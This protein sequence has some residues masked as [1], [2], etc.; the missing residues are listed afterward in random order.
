[1]SVS[2]QQADIK[3]FC[4]LGKSATETCV[5]FTV[6]HA[7]EARENSSVYDRYTNLKMVKN[8]LKIRNA[9]AGQHHL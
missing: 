8:H 9:L 3:F 1:M 4:K 6:G 2:E 5:S 7:A